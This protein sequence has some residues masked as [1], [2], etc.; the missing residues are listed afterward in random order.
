MALS[1][2]DMLDLSQ[3][4]GGGTWAKKLIKKT[5]Q[6]ICK[7]EKKKATSAHVTC[8]RRPV[9]ILSMERAL[10]VHNGMGSGN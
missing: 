1:R 4:C 8:Y 9:F 6:Y 2:A 10:I 5:D 7:K 3:S